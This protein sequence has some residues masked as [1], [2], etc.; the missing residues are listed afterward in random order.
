MRA[1]E[2]Y[3]E[4]ALA[5]NGSG[6]G[7]GPQ[8][9]LLDPLVGHLLN[10]PR[11]IPPADQHYTME[12]ELDRTAR[13]Y[14]CMKSAVPRFPERPPTPPNVAMQL[15]MQRMADREER[16]ARRRGGRVL[17]L[18]GTIADAVQRA[19]ATERPTG[20]PPRPPGVARNISAPG[21]EG[22]GAGREEQQQPDRLPRGPRRR[23][24]SRPRGTDSAS[25]DAK[26]RSVTSSGEVR[27]VSRAELALASVARAESFAKTGSAEALVPAHL[28]GLSIPPVGHDRLHSTGSPPARAGSGST[29]RARRQEAAPPARRR[30]SAPRAGADAARLQQG[31]VR[32][33]PLPTGRRPS[34]A[35]RAKPAGP[36]CTRAGPPPLAKEASPGEFVMQFNPFSAS[37]A[38]DSAAALREIG[39]RSRQGAREGG[40]PDPSEQRISRKGRYRR[41]QSRGVESQVQDRSQVRAASLG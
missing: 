6:S 22:G 14:S 39:R 15:L 24:R 34:R 9:G 41:P 28:R 16:D 36:A 17:D 21:Q 20:P 23:R 35:P 25:P 33:D 29:G 37:A 38:A 11:G 12:A 40:A 32:L 26:M 5:P 4:V 30:S 7:S 10:A 2:Q 1:F 3:R 18:H 19:A 8:R 27:D 13:T 31:P